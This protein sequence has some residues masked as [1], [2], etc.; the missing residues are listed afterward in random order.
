MY[1]LNYVYVCY[2][3]TI[4]QLPTNCKNERQSIELFEYKLVPEALILI[5]IA[6]IPDE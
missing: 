2:R 4:Y 5:L 6:I 1:V 3:T